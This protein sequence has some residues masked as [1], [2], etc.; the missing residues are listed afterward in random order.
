MKP[1]RPQKSY[2]G[3]RGPDGLAVVRVIELDGST[4]P[5]RLRL[6][7]TNHSPTGF[8]WGYD[9]SGPAQLA[10]A[11]LADATGDDEAAVRLHQQFKFAVIGRL[12]RDQSWIMSELHVLSQARKLK[13]LERES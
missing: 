7:L 6:D 3:R 2:C 13:R 4:R 9:G 1:A 5:L 8:E 11:L 12:Q 10:L